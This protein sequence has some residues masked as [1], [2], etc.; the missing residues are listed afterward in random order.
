[1]RELSCGYMASLYIGISAPVWPHIC[2]FWQVSQLGLAVYGVVRNWL[3]EFT[4]VRNIER[5]QF[6]PILL[7]HYGG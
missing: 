2:L 1:M 4:P 3:R 5:L 7:D 6:N